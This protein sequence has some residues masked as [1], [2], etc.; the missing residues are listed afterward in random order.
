MRTRHVIGILFVLMACPLVLQAGGPEL[1]PGPFTCSTE[2]IPAPK[3]LSSDG[4]SRLL[5]NSII[6]LE[7]TDQYLWAATGNGLARMSHVGTGIL[8]S[9][10]ANG[11]GSGGVSGLAPCVTSWGAEV[12]WAATAIDTTISGTD[13]A[14]GGGVGYSL[15]NGETW[16]WMS[17]PVDPVDAEGM[18]PT[19][20]SV[21]NVTYDIA[22]L[23]DRVWIAS[24]AG[25]L[26]YFDMTPERLEAG[27]DSV[28]WV[29]RPPDD[30]EFDVLNNLNHRAFSIAVMDT[31]LWVGTAAGI[32]LS[33]DNGE[34]W[35][36]FSHSGTY[37]GTI[38]GN[39]VTAMGVQEHSNGQFALWAATWVAEGS[40][41]YY[42]VSM[43][44]DYGSTWRRVMGSIENPVR[45]HNFAFSDT[46]A[47]VATDDGLFKSVDA[48]ENW[49]QFPQIHDAASGETIYEPEIYSAATNAAAP[50]RLYA[51][52]PGGL[53]ISPDRGNRWLI[54][55]SFPLPGRN[56]QPN[57]YAYP[58][59]F[60]P[61]RFDVVRIQYHLQ[62]NGSVTLEIYD[63]AMEL[64]IRLV[65][66]EWR[67]AGERCEI[68][69]GYGPNG[70]EIANGVYFYRLEVAGKESWGKIMILD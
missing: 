43:T 28:E 10:P 17:Q 5:S 40:S 60:S 23:N 55:R 16:V 20:V 29:N 70:A 12:I 8:N 54:L 11:F 6:D 34:T 19:T 62:N 24:W 41:Q 35:Q 67:S 33:R 22:V 42:G 63:F 37:D 30:E 51:G 52:G 64:L 59:P 2:L 38:T 45:A 57:S 68:W 65:D 44:N 61:S 21:Q 13:Y 47:Y 69:N 32:N 1:Y 66:D 15:D 25:G 18:S 9:T 36:R 58:N 48:G 14:A 56:G 27:R 26:R 50:E 4:D 39:F 31:M 53:A 46:I 3:L 7:L 49:G